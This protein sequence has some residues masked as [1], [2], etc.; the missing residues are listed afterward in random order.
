MN[1]SNQRAVCYLIDS[2]IPIWITNWAYKTS[3]VLKHQRFE[4][5]G[6]DKTEP[7]DSIRWRL[8]LHD[9]EE[10]EGLDE[11]E[12]EDEGKDIRYIPF[13]FVAPL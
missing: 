12:V 13:P 8:D 4:D 3:A 10:G 9:D 7:R 1:F 11:F 2:G 5:N 6:I